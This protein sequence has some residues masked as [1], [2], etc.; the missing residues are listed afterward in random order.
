MDKHWKEHRKDIAGKIKIMEKIVQALD[1]ALKVLDASDLTKDEAKLKDTWTEDKRVYEVQ[2]RQDKKD[3]APPA[4]EKPK[5]A[6]V[7]KPKPVAKAA[8]TKA[9]EKA[10]ADP[11][12]KLDKFLADG[13]LDKVEKDILLKDKS[14][15]EALAAAPLAKRTELLAR[16]LQA[17]PELDKKL[18]K[19][20]DYYNK[21]KG[22]WYSAFASADYVRSEAEKSFA[23]VNLTL[24]EG[25]MLVETYQA[26]K[27]LKA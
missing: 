11:I 12:A 19:G 1:E 15:K 3:I 18:K 8:P 26:L 24:K 23:E 2:I 9:P 20:S 14:F 17:S 25:E 27:G 10:K 13:T 16:I 21:E 6:P 4:P 7:E 5:P 22:G